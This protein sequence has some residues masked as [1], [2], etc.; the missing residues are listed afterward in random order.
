MN[1]VEIRIIGVTARNK[2]FKIPVFPGCQVLSSTNALDLFP[3][4]YITESAK[5]RTAYVFNFQGA[6]QIKLVNKYLFNALLIV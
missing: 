5:A 6:R 3:R 2:T 1:I 4:P